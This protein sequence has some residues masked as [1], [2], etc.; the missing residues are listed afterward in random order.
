MSEQGGSGNRNREAEFDGETCSEKKV[1]TGPLGE[2]SS[3][4]PQIRKDQQWP[5][6]IIPSKG[7]IHM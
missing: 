3:P 2:L 6:R 4:T 1:K 5:H 7:T